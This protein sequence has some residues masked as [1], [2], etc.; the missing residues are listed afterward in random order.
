[1]S[2]NAQ[3]SKA[4]R[5]GNLAGMKLIQGATFLMGSEGFYPEEAPIRRAAIGAFWIDEY[6]VTN[7]QFAEFVDATR[8]KTFAETAPDPRDYPG[9]PPEMARAGSAVFTPT[10]GPVPLNNPGAWWTF[11]FG[12]DW[13]RPLGPDSSIAD[14]MDHPVVQIAYEDAQAYAKW[15]GKDLPTEA[16]WEFAARGGAEQKPFAWGDELAPEGR[17]MANTWQGEFPWRNSRADGFERTSPVG[18]FP[19]NDF[20][21]FDMIGNVWEWTTDWYS[22]TTTEPGR[23]CCG[24]PRARTV[25]KSESYDP[26]SPQVKIARKVCKGGSH[27]CAPNYCQRYRP[28]A[29]H[30]QSVDSPT[31]HVGFRCIARM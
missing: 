3:Q 12:A 2:G 14:I 1:M 18:A 13:R 31:S 17:A 10:R 4:V 24:P 9:M 25:H 27:L 19:Q 11:V 16:E 28:A 5:R 21:L 23:S 20:G 6:P 26:L 29:R 22:P 15:A 30:P 7:R 8:Y